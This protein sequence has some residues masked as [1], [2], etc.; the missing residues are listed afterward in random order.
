MTRDSPI[1]FFDGTCG[2][3]SASVRW[4]L[5]HDRKGLL[6]F[7][8]L[9]GE[10]YAHL[11][12][13]DKPMDM[14][15]MVFVQRNE[16][17]VGSDAVAQILMAMG[18]WPGVLGLKLWAIPRPIR[19]WLYRTLSAHRYEIAGR[20]ERCEIPSESDRAKLLP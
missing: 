2:M 12:R 10:T 7:A 4:M 3:C 14:N 18:G 16:L 1:V 20:V 8:P 17:Y 5:R 15:S 9:R 19:D 6:R 11:D 13:A